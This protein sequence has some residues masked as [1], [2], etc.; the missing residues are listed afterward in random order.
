MATTPS[1]LLWIAR[2][3]A[4]AYGSAE[5]E[6]SRIAQHKS[7]LDF[8]LAA[9]KRAKE[10]LVEA[11]KRLRSAKC[12]KSRYAAILELHEV[13]LD[14]AALP[15]VRPHQLPRTAGYGRMTKVI[16]RALQNA[17][18]A[19]LSTSSIT[20]AVGKDSGWKG[21]DRQRIHH[22][23]QVRLC[24]LASQGRIAGSLA[25]RGQDRHWHLIS[26]VPSVRGP[27]DGVTATEG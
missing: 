27:Q 8:H 24:I 7:C 2:R 20:Q 6:Q 11:R 9:A 23:V 19:G 16:Y 13:P 10:R 3:Y 5:R 22:R 4:Y 18:A 1:S 14:V 12:S 26:E 25:P 21:L 17:G 15:A